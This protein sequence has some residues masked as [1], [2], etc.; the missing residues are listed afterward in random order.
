MPSGAHLSQM[1]KKMKS[2]LESITE[3]INSEEEVM[4]W[5]SRLSQ[6]DD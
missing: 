3:D 1:T 2:G 4:K 5:Q 6:E